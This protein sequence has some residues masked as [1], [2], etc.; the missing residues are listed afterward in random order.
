MS[1]DEDDQDARRQY[2]EAEADVAAGR[3]EKAVDAF[4]ELFLHP[5]IK[6]DQF[7][8]MHHNV[9]LCLGHLG[10]WEKALEHALQCGFDEASFTEFMAKRGVHAGS[11]EELEAR[12]LYAEANAAFEA[13]DDERC[14]DLNAELMIHGGTTAAMMPALHWNMAMCL[15]RMG[16]WDTAIEHVHAGKY[17]VGEFEATMEM[18]GVFRPTG[19]EE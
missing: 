15:A 1:L 11:P 7:P 19:D 8:A 3:Y 16:R 17:E 10:E 6:A 13:G 9:A 12:R 18:R 5:G 14:L 2:Y 4:V